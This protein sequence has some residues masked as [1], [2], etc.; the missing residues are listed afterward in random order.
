MM[1]EQS[2]NFGETRFWHLTFLQYNQP[3]NHSI[4]IRWH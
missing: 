3:H 1:G 4:G 2:A